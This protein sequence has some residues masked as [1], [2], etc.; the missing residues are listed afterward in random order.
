MKRRNVRGMTTR[1]SG[2]IILLALLLSGC[3]LGRTAQEVIGRQVSGL[4][5]KN[6]VVVPSISADRY[7]YEQ[8]D[9]ETKAVYDQILQCILEHEEKVTVSTNDSEVLGRAYACMLMDYGGLFWISGYQYNTYT[10]FD[11]V[12]GL[13][14]QPN[15]IYTADETRELQAEVDAVVEEW[16]A[17]IS[18]ND[19]DYEKVKYVFETLIDRVDYCLDSR[20]N[21]NILSVFLY[22]ETVCQG[23]ADAAQYLLQNLG[24]SCAV[25]TG[26]AEGGNHAWNM[27]K[28]DGD[29]YYMDVTWGNSRYRSGEE[30]EK[31]HVNYAYLSTTLEDISK[32]HRADVPVDLPQSL[33][34]EDTYFVREGLYFETFDPGAIGRRIQS[35]WWEGEDRIS[36]RLA[37]ETIHNE[38]LEYFVTDQHIFSYCPGLH[39]IS[40]LDEKTLGIITFIF[41]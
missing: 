20:D 29:Y 39:S 26:N 18:L 24:I 6:A 31:K 22:G 37:D 3:G 1:F 11:T 10:S 23:Y 12:V 8:L 41:P 21:Q 40:Y 28:L 38:T 27:V 5:V 30:E 25:V 36:I 14:F 7:A 17:G 9:M 33:S 35:T 4:L 34:R 32:S 16:M 2:L 13:E 19:D 15:Y